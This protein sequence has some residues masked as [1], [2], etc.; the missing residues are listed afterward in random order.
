MRF[1]VEVTP[2]GK[3]DTQSVCVE[4]ESC[5]RALQVVRAQRGEPAQ[6]AGFSIELLDD[7]YRA[8]DPGARLR[9]VV[10]RVE[11]DRPL[12]PLASGGAREADQAPNQA[13]MIPH[14]SSG[15]VVAAAP[16]P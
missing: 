1:L 10:K 4:A 16:V 12:T 11:D 8:V 13:R 2:I 6:M 14:Q 7:G 5:Q 3:T 15:R 9:Y